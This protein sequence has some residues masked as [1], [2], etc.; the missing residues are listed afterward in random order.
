M[1]TFTHRTGISC[2]IKRD[3]TGQN[4]LPEVKHTSAEEGHV[5]NDDTYIDNWVFK[6]PDIQ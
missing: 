1:I 4:T 2:Y 5:E 6:C 3:D